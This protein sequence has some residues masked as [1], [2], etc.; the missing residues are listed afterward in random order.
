MALTLSDTMTAQDTP[1]IVFTAYSD[2]MLRFKHTAGA[3]TVHLQEDLPDDSDWM[4]V[5]ASTTNETVV[6][7]VPPGTARKFRMTIATL[8]TGPV[9]WAVRGKLN[10]ND[11][12]GGAIP[13]TVEIQE[14]GD[15]SVEEDGTTIVY[16]EA[17]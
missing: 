1:S 7:E 16:E 14:N 11:T 5:Y 6:V 13:S 8:D 3:S 17:A 10:A 15:Q 2:F 4:T 12:I 9:Q